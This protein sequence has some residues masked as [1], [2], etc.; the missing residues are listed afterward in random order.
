M[1]SPVTWA[2]RTFFW[3]FLQNI[4]LG[5]RFVRSARI[6]KEKTYRDYSILFLRNQLKKQ[7][8]YNFSVFI[9]AKKPLESFPFLGKLH[10]FRL[11]SAVNIHFLQLV[12]GRRIWS[13][14]LFFA[15][16]RFATCGCFPCKKQ[17]YPDGIRPGQNAR[18]LPCY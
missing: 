10:S 6:S 12:F 14:Q 16:F 13:S 7:K 9:L 1:Y 3:V 18:A 2:V 4:P 11:L 15:V 5:R 8:K 17:L